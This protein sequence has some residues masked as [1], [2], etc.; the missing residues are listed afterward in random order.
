MIKYGSSAIASVK[1]GGQRIAKVYH[2]SDLVW[3]ND[4]WVELHIGSSRNGDPQ[5]F[6]VGGSLIDSS[7]DGKYSSSGSGFIID[8][9]YQ[10]NSDGHLR[11]L[12]DGNLSTFT[13]WSNS[14]SSATNPPWIRI[15]F[16]FDIYIQSITLVDSSD[17]TNIGTSVCSIS[18]NKK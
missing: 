6:I 4:E 8:S 13:T 15:K 5:G 16:P 18:R 7:A 2:G 17:Y 14:S 11:R 10:C 3:G 1:Y 9:L 12:F